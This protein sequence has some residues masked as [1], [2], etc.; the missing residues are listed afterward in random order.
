MRRRSAAGVR[1]VSSATR[2]GRSPS[3]VPSSRTVSSPSSDA[4]GELVLLGQHL[5]RGHERA[6]VAALHGGEQRGERDDRLA[7]PDLALQ[8]PVH[9]RR[10][11][12]VVGDLRDGRCL[13]VGERERQRGVERGHERHRR[14]TCSIPVAS[15]ASARLRATRASC[16][17][18]NSSNFSRLRGGVPVGRR[19][20]AGGCRGTRC[21]GRRGRASARSRS[22]SGSAKPRALVRSRHDA[23]ARRSCHVCTSAFPDCGYTGTMVPVTSEPAS[24]SA[25]T[26]TTGLVIWRFP[27]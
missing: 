7:R 1:L 6:L 18:R 11:R 14:A 8:Q 5:G 13:V 19:S 2:T 17:R 16:M 15:A 22:S 23:T 4:H 3:S 27:R 20:R 9:R 24:G 26:S 12:H 21:P 10:A 25:S